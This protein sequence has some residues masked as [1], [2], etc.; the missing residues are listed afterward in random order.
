MKFKILLLLF[1]TFG[2]M[3]KVC[4]MS[5]AQM[6]SFYTKMRT[7]TPAT[8][9]YEAMGMTFNNAEQIIGKQNG[10]CVVKEEISPRQV[11]VCKMPMDVTLKYAD[12]NLRMIKTSRANGNSA[13]SSKFVNSVMNN[14]DYCNIEFKR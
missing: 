13:T 2:F 9:S 14:P 3:T 1:A 7:C 11:M 4:A 6:E 5:E 10:R 12:E 8:V